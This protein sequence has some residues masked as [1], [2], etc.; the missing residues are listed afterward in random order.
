MAEFAYKS[1]AWVIGTTSFRTKDFNLNIERQLELLSEF[2]EKEENKLKDWT[3][4]NELQ[5]KYY[6]FI[7]SKGFLGG[8]APRP[9]KDAREKTSGLVEIGLLTDERRL[10]SAGES[11]LKVAQSGEFEPDNILGLNKDSYIY[12]KQLLKTTVKMNEG[13]VRPFLVFLYITDKLGYLSYDEFR[14][15]LP[16]CSSEDTLD[17]II[18]YIQKLRD[19]TVTYDDVIIATLLN[20]DN[21]KEALDAFLEREVTEE[22][23]CEIGINRKSRKYDKPYFKIY[24]QLREIVFDD[25]NNIEKILKSIGDLSQ[26]MRTP[27]RNFLF[28]N[29]NVNIIKGDWK[30]TLADI[31]LFNA[32]T[33]SEFR[34]EFFKAMHL[35]KAKATLQD[36]FDLNR[37][38]FK[39]TD[40]V[41]FEDQKVHL[42]IMPGIYAREISTM[43]YG[44]AFVSNARLHEDTELSE[45]AEW[46]D[47]DEGNLYRRLSDEYGI[48]VDTAAE[49]RKF[50]RDDRYKRFNQLI[51]E[52]F[53]IPV[54]LDLLEKFKNRED[55]DIRNAV[56]DNADI[57]TIFEY[58]L[59][60]AWYIISD[61]RGDVL[62]YMNLSLE[63]DLLPKTHASGG[64]ADIVWKYEASDS[65]P[66]HTLLIEATLSDGTNQRRMEMEP[67]SRHLG[68]YKIAHPDEE[69]YCIFVATYLHPNVI[70]DFQSRKHAYYYDLEGKEYFRGMKIMSIATD[71][72]KTLL[73]F[74]VKYPQVYSLLDSA[75]SADEPAVEWYKNNIVK[76]V[77]ILENYGKSR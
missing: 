74:N 51:D 9:D 39:A 10:T 57:P 66:K 62:E 76:E 45:I 13:V 11:L 65:Y 41:I 63:A 55:D 46:F 47:V 31:D 38:Y 49:V 61:R 20:M 19:G 25:K 7:R 43:L 26:G 69:A 40:A 21:Y 8:E 60:I 32:K 22:L 14:Y 50:I 28:K 27:W 16:L 17:R 75:Y 2:W 52:R 68:D 29:T 36:Y 58:I 72:L 37:R 77:G 54:L 5:A 35:L 23:I 4:N 33:E 24:K 30:E 73:K 1:Y 6:E 44:E 56:T 64:E 42:D 70:A 18:G 34:T 3:G 15:L 71:E 53:D 12:F 67:V 59:A 48:K